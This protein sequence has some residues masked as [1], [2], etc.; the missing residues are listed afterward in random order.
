MQQTC[1]CE[2]RNCIPLQ[3]KRHTY[4]PIAD[5]GNSFIRVIGRP[6]LT[7]NDI[8]Q[9]ST[10]LIEWVCKECQNVFQKDPNSMLKRKTS[11]TFE[12]ICSKCSRMRAG[13]LTNERSENP[14]EA[15]FP[16]EASEF[17]RNL[18]IPTRTVGSLNA[19]SHDTCEWKC[20]Y[21]SQIWVS[22]VDSRT[23]FPR[24]KGCPSCNKKKN[25]ALYITNHNGVM[26]AEAYPAI[27]K[28]L[29]SLINYPDVDI[30]TVSTM[31]NQLAT[32]QCFCGSTFKRK[33][34]R[35]VSRKSIYC[36]ACTKSGKSL[37][38]FEVAELLSAM[39]GYKISMHH[40][41]AP[42]QPEVDLYVQDLD[43]GIQLDP[44]WSHYSRYESDVRILNNLRET[45]TKAV[46]VRQSSLPKIAGS[47][48]PAGASPLEWALAA[49]LV[50][51][52]SPLT[53]NEVEIEQALLKANDNWSFIMQHVKIK[54][55]CMR[56]PWAEEFVKNLT[57]PG[58]KIE[59]STK[60]SEDLCLW[61]CKACNQE[62][63]S[64]IM[65][66]DHRKTP[67]KGCS[68]LS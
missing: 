25:S 53:L 30:K 31:S 22:R 24:G 67:H 6:C 59:Y 23:K 42:T 54:N 50:L 8:F 27:A 18:D 7:I 57:H 5:E 16:E 60:G 63:E 43:C 28:Q 15:L 2:G 38:E 14:F 55:S 10:L 68:L 29:I 61:K 35:V 65:A 40:T 52:D 4:M 64:K 36:A 1:N 46:R 20:F 12:I 17:V 32:W 9:N 13:Q 39:T 26:L 37:F 58:K 49:S 34:N 33:V 62:W 51:T 66:R 44:Y 3:Q 56:E 19:A 41:K 11:T 48:E 47:P 21:C 45:Y